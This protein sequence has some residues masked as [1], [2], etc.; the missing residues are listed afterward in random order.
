M[1]VMTTTEVD[2]VLILAQLR[3]DLA[4]GRARQIR[5]NARLSQA[6]IARALGTNV[7]TVTRWE[8]GVCPR[9]ENA[10]KY[11]TLLRQLDEIGRTAS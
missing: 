2:E 5:E 10:I 8:G 4:S 7:P 3:A 1:C 11:A 6:D 9:R